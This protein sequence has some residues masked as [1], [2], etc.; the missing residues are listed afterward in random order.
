ML[1]IIDSFLQMHICATSR[2][3]TIYQGLTGKKK[4]EF[5]PLTDFSTDEILPKLFYF[6]K[7]EANLYWRGGNYTLCAYAP[8][9]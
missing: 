8:S 2:V 9:T 1:H 5:Y 6:S 7:S 3:Q 4:E